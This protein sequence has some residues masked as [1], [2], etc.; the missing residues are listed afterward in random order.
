MAD[1]KPK[2]TSV[3]LF[4]VAYEEHYICQSSNGSPSLEKKKILL[5][6]VAIV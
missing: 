6:K 4:Y 1:L 2:I 3:M 5:A